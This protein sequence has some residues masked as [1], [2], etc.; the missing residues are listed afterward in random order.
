[1]S[2]PLPEGKQIGRYQIRAKIGEGGMGEVYVARDDQISRDL[3][4]KVLPAA[5]SADT[6][7]L[8]R[9]EQEAQAAGSLNHPNILVVYD[10]GTHDGAP[11]VVSIRPVV[12]NWTVELK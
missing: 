12:L 11:Y 2:S 9:F 10:I 5:F 8:R 4:I 7:R 3:A 1:M 6:E